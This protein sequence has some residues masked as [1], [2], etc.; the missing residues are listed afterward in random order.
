MIPAGVAWGFLPNFS[1]PADTL[2]GQCH[3]ADNMGWRYL[4]YT[5]GS[6][7]F[8]LWAGRFFLFTLHESPKYLI[9]Q[10][11]YTEA[12]EVLNAV[13]KYNKTSQPLTVTQL[14]QVERHHAER[15]GGVHAVAP[16]SRKTAIKRTF[17]AF[18]PGGFHHV[19]ALF[20]TVKLTYSFTLILLIWGMIGLGSP[21]YSNFL[22]EYLAR[23][24]AQ[25]GDASINTTYRNNFIIIV[26][27]LPGTLAGGWLVGLRHVGR[28]GTLGGS[29]ILAAV[30]LF[31]FT[32]ART[33]AQNL[34]FN[35]VA[36][37]VQYM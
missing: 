25:A 15:N 4:M 2:A 9:G 20:S 6:F 27:S 5:M 13:A 31:A 7:T 30:F 1:C 23:H 3:K 18:K 8:V 34:A 22:P 24:G 16:V 29:L 11:R 32:T 14:E 10:G 28:K 37:F 17:A 19:R 12:I 26:C 35:C 33:N 36:T 21:L